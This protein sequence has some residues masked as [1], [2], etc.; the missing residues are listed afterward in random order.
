LLPD[1]ILVRLPFSPIS[2]I[3]AGIHPGFIT[4][5]LDTCNRLAVA[6]SRYSY[7]TAAYCIASA[8]LLSSEPGG[9]IY[10]KLIHVDGYTQFIVVFLLARELVQAPA[11]NPTTVDFSGFLPTR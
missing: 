3:V 4:G 8:F 9:L 5:S 6:F 10:S 11:M 7:T 1:S 2:P